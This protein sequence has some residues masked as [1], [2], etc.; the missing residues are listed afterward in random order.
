MFLKNR[1]II[2]KMKI[3]K[4]TD[5]A[6]LS[7]KSRVRVCLFL[8]LIVDYHTVYPS[9]RFVDIFTTLAVRNNVHISHQTKKCAPNKISKRQA[10]SLIW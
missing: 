5:Y 7:D 10:K 8:H 4:V 9:N 3:S 1:N 6:A 2:F